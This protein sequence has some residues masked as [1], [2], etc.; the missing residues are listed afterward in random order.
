MKES[1]LKNFAKFTGK[2][3]CQS[4]FFNKVAGLRTATLFKKKNSSTGVFLWILQNLSKASA[5]ELLR[6][7]V[8]DF[9]YLQIGI[10]GRTGAGKSSLISMLLRL[11]EMSGTVKIDGYDIIKLKL[12]N[13]RK[14]ISVI[15]QVRRHYTFL[16]TFLYIIN[17]KKE[18]FEH[19]IS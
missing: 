18:I 16:V 8:S 4:L 17:E 10:V 6:T 2:H 1:V 3:Q 5:T 14:S 13:L 7:T 19:S 9:S 15:P 12:K 11:G